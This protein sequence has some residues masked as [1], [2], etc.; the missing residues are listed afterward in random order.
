MNAIAKAKLA[1]IAEAEGFPTIEAM[2]EAAAA[3]SICPGICAGCDFIVSDVEPDQD[4]G[5]CENC[6]GNTVQSALIVAGLI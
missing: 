4:Q 2:L 6:D 5:W 1:K 3:D